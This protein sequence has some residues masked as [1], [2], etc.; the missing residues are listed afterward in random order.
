[1]ED[2][3]A[4]AKVRTALLEQDEALRKACEDMATVRVAA[5]EFE[6]D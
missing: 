5:A 1:M 4:V 2:A 3:S 6:R